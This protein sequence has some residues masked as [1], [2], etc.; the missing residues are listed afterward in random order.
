MKELFKEV[1][2]NIKEISIATV[3]AIIAYIKISI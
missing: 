2:R 1:F 3:E